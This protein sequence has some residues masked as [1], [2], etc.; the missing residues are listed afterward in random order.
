MG[1]GTPHSKNSPSRDL[2]PI[3]Q[4]HFAGSRAVLQQAKPGGAADQGRK[5]RGD[6]NQSFLSSV[7]RE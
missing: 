3:I 6:L 2:A 7:P 4:A 1:S 5:A